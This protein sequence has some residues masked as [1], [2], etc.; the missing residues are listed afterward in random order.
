MRIAR[1][2]LLYISYYSLSSVIDVIEISISSMIF[3]LF[4][5]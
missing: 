5:V 2:G 4:W 1:E 3:V